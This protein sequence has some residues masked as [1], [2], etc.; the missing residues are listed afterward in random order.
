M[1]LISKIRLGGTLQINTLDIPRLCREV[2]KG[3]INTKEFNNFVFSDLQQARSF[4]IDYSDLL[5]YA[6]SI[7]GQLGLRFE[8]RVSFDSQPMVQVTMQRVQ[9]PAGGN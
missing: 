3:N 9:I 8:K 4:G 6:E 5:S 2:S 1:S 7:E